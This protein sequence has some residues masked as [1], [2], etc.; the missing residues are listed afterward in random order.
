LNSNVSSAEI[1]L[2]LT[3]K[4]LTSVNLKV[5]VLINFNEEPARSTTT[6]CKVS[7]EKA[8]QYLMS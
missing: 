7:C 5:A 8:S 4:D 3:Y 2:G 6:S 1:T